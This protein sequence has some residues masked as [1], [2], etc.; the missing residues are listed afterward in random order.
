MSDFFLKFNLPKPEF[1]INHSHKLTFLGSCFS[2]EISNRASESGFHVLSN[3]FGTIYHPFAL[4]KNIL[5]SIDRNTNFPLFERDGLF[6]SW[7]ASTKISAKSRG[8]LEERIVTKNIQLLDHLSQPGVLFITFG[9]AHIYKVK[10]EHRFVANCH[11]QPGNLFDKE[12]SSVE[13]IVE[14]WQ[15]ILSK[16]WQINPDLKLVFTVSPVRHIRDGI[17]ENNRSKAR[18]VQAVEEL[19]K[20]NNVDYF[21]SYEIVMDELRDYRFFKEDRVH[22]S[23]EA[24]NYI[25]KRFSESYFNDHTQSI[26]LELS[27][28]RKR[29][30]HR[31][32]QKFDLD[33]KTLKSMEFFQNEFPWVNWIVEK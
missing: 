12:I 10:S 6:F 25:W 14:L 8:E 24:V 2:D 13:S 16:L 1:T 32:V 31:S 4:A 5:D 23:E 20:L 22:P 29:I 15:D 9:T 3:P 30:A 18:L 27:K 28:I 33:V 11:K 7:D 19:V 26:V 17:I 21:P